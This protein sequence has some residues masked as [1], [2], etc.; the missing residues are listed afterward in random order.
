MKIVEPSVEIMSHIDGIEMLKNIELYART[1]YKSEK[2]ITGDSCLQFVQNLI[3]RGH[4]AMLEHESITVKIICDR[5][6]SHEWVR[7]RVASYAQESTRYVK[8]GDID[9]IS[10]VPFEWGDEE[11]D[12]R[13]NVWYKAMLDSE[14]AYKKLIDLGCPPQEARSVLPNSL[15]TELIC[16]MNL[17]EWRHFFF[18]RAAKGAHPQIRLI[19]KQLLSAFRVHIP[20]VFDKIKGKR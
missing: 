10:P 14:E 15:K 18:L 1:C 5:G 4:E 2:K 7:H 3:D 17:R 8:Y 20:V 12:E 16:T 9:V 13:H 11:N 6:V 19:A